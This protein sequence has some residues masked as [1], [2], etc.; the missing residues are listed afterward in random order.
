[1]SP[2]DADRARQLLEHQA[3]LR[4]ALVVGRRWYLR[5]TIMALVA[6]IALYRGGHVNV[7]IGVAMLLL[8][9]LSMSLGRNMRRGGMDMERKI[10]LMEQGTP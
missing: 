1:V 5:G 9:V 4:R 3:A 8:A 7:L 6:A 10:Q 2:P